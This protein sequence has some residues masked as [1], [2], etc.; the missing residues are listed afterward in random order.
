MPELSSSKPGASFFLCL[1]A[2]TGFNGS[3]GRESRHKRRNGTMTPEQRNEDAR[4][5]TS[6]KPNGDAAVRQ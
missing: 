2:P 1:L 3:L 5:L 6:P 4:E